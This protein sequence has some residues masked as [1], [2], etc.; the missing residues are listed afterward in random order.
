M[1]LLLLEISAY[2]ETWVWVL[3]VVALLIIVFTA[4]SNSKLSKKVEEYERGEFNRFKARQTELIQQM[5][6]NVNEQKLALLQEKSN[7]ATKLKDLQIQQQK[8]KSELKEA[9][10]KKYSE[11]VNALRDSQILQLNEKQKMLQQEKSTFT[12]KL[13]E[14]SDL[15]QKT[16]HEKIMEFRDKETKYK[17]DLDQ[18]Y[19]EWADREL[20]KYKKNEVEKY[21]TVLLQE[22]KGE[23]EIRIRQDAIKRSGSVNFGKI[24]EHL[25]PFYSSFPFNHKDVRFIG[26]P[27]DLIVFDG[28]DEHRDDITIYIIEVKT[29]NSKLSSRQQHI[30][31]AVEN[32]NVKWIEIN[33]D[34][35]I[36]PNQ[37]EFDFEEKKEKPY[38]FQ[39]DIF[40]SQNT[41]P[42]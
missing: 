36:N 12:T 25:F 8:E 37:R 10:Y 23:N 5:K 3:G 13:K 19:K 9:E 27:I 22:W 28:H 18:F 2:G 6:D 38:T 14:Q 31:R 11:H 42:I 32:K 17:A 7:Y 1:G 40:N 41:E 15:Y 29:G 34:V 30:K 33:P 39:K 26:S 35:I 16:L 24:T 21:A 4:H 20:D